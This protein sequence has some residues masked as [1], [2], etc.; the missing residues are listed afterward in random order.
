[1]N[2][3]NKT[4]TKTLIINDLDCDLFLRFKSKLVLDGKTI[5]GE[6]TRFMDSYVKNE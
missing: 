1:M 3:F 4:G 6:I 5:K 2:E